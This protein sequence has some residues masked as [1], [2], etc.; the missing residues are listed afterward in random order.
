[1][2][3]GR[4]APSVAAVNNN[5]LVIGGRMGA[6]EATIPGVTYTVDSAEIYEPE[7]SRWRDG[8]AMPT[9]RCEAA[10]AVL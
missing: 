4:I 5:L 1:M 9:S 6:E 8:I 7:T 2:S 3:V 10:T